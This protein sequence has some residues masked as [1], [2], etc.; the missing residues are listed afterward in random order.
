MPIGIYQSFFHRENN[1][2]NRL[3]GKPAT[4]FRTRTCSQM[5]PLGY[6]VARVSDVVSKIEELQEDFIRVR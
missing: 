3:E 6:P 2:F 5:K 4:S 1:K